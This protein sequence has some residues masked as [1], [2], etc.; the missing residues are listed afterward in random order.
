MIKIVL[1]RSALEKLGHAHEQVELCDESGRV[2][3]YFVPARRTT[4]YPEGVVPYTDEELTR[5]EQEPGARPL[6][7]I[8][9]E[10]ERGA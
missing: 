4:V 3:G 2:L 5:F 8:L 7:D 9:A 1:D 6:A 10:L